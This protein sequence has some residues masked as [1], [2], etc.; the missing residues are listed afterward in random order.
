VALIGGALDRNGLEV[1]SR[2]DC[3]RLIQDVPVG[4]VAVVVGGIPVVVPVNFVVSD[5]DVTFRTGTGAKLAAA[6]HRSA[7]SFEVDSLDSGSHTG[8]SVL[9]TGGASEITRPDEKEVAAGL[10]LRSWVPGRARYIRVRAET[11]TGRRLC[12]SPP[13]LSVPETDWDWG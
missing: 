2:E 1:L 13:P 3:L 11:V 5:G 6:V 12:G 4:R 10:G 9:I 8:W 7:V